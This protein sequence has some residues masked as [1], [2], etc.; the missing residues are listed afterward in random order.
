MLANTIFLVILYINVYINLYMCLCTLYMYIC[1]HWSAAQPDIS[2]P[3][4][5]HRE[6]SHPCRIDIDIVHCRVDQKG[7][8]IPLAS[9][10]TRKLQGK[11]N[12]VELNHGLFDVDGQG[13][14][15]CL[16]KIIAGDLYFHCSESTIGDRLMISFF[17]RLVH[18]LGMK[19]WLE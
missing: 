3:D 19:R 5:S 13:T 8:G 15:I 16:L 14:P 2:Y 1:K 9:K 10:I 7:F 11:P 17:P 18:F 6:S 4:I 12:F